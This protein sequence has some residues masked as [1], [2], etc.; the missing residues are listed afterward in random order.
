MLWGGSA[1]A[2][3]NRAGC[4]R[5]AVGCGPAPGAVEPTGAR[6]RAPHRV[7]AD[8]RHRR[9]VGEPHAPEHRPDGG[10]ALARVQAARGRAA[11]PAGGGSH[12]RRGRRQQRLRTSDAPGRAAGGGA[13]TVGRWHASINAPGHA[14]TRRRVGGGGH[15]C[16]RARWLPGPAG[17]QA[18]E[19]GRGS[20]ARRRRPA[21]RRPGGRRATG[22]P[23]RQWRSPPGRPPAAEV[24]RG[25]GRGWARLGDSGGHGGGG[26][27]RGGRLVQAGDSLSSKGPN[28]ASAVAAGRASVKRSPNERP[29]LLARMGVSLMARAGGRGRGVS[30]ACAAG[31][32][33]GADSA[34]LP[35]RRH[36]RRPRRYAAGAG[37]PGRGAA[38]GQRLG[39]LVPMQRGRA[40][41]PPA[42]APRWRRRSGRSGARRRA[43][44]SRPCWRPCRTC[45]TW[46]DP[47]RAHVRQPEARPRGRARG[48]AASS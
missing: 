39:G 40:R 18:G 11:V 35:A 29:G 2:Q 45:R 17:K 4:Q 28:K 3:R 21:R 43:G 38:A 41:R 42:P 15:L 7:G 44:R 26:G 30:A 5:S 10:R 6:A 12:A 25:R 16:S 9:R 8:Q 34:Q 14:T 20:N 37:P 31:A 47:R 36:V 22:S 13:A 33:T 48:G 23:A 46:A 1:G 32:G 27:G 24:C 19:R